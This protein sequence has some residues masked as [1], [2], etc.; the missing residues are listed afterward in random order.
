M[1]ISSLLIKLTP[2]PRG[3]H[4]LAVDILTYFSL[5]HNMHVLVFDSPFLHVLQTICPQLEHLTAKPL[6]HIVFNTNP[7]QVHFSYL[8]SSTVDFCNS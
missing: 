6:L 2:P 8:P 4:T 1:A 7:Q 3:F 5:K